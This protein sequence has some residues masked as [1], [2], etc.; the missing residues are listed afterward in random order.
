MSQNTAGWSVM[1]PDMFLAE[2]GHVVYA[3]EHA[4]YTNE[5]SDEY[6]VQHDEVALPA[7]K[8]KDKRRRIGCVCVETVSEST[9]TI[10]TDV[11]GSMVGAD[12]LLTNETILYPSPADQKGHHCH[13]SNGGLLALLSVVLL[14]GL[15]V[16]VS[17]GAYALLIVKPAPSIDK[18][19]ESFAIPNHLASRR[20][21]A[22][23]SAADHKRGIIKWYGVRKRSVSPENPEH[24]T[25][26]HHPQNKLQNDHTLFRHKRS[27]D[28]EY[29]KKG[30]RI[31]GSTQ[32]IRQWKLTIV[33]VAQ[34]GDDS[35]IFTQERLRDI[36]DIEMKMME[37]NDFQNYCLIDYT[38]L[39]NDP[40]LNKY[41]G[42]APLNTLLTYFYPTVVGEHGNRTVYFNSFGSTLYDEI[43]TTLSLAMTHSSFYWYVDDQINKVNKRSKLMR[44]EVHF[45]TPALG[46]PQIMFENYIK[47]LLNIIFDL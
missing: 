34:G 38:A 43:S 33:Y 3:N 41:N 2:Y 36:H 4:F 24:S 10:S 39:E 1:K 7:Q 28:P 30:R 5:Y 46:R 40:T 27:D 25:F 44:T 12:V 47:L 6:V 31:V 22:L 8:K 13:I 26:S 45:A 18:S 19:I 11:L 32:A 29:Y 21:D 14:C 9:S 16:P 20:Y 23:R 17:L 37:H 42:C 15:A 35:N